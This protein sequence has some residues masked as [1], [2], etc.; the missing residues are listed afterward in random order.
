MSRCT[1]PSKTITHTTFHQIIKL[2]NEVSALHPGADIK[3]CN[4][5]RKASILKKKLEKINT[6]N[7]QGNEN[8]KI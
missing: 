7:T 6:Q 4:T 8:I 5:V 3:F 1:R 2:L